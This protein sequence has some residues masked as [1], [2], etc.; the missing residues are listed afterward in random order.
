[1]GEIHKGSLRLERSLDKV[2]HAGIILVRDGIQVVLCLQNTAKTRL[3][4]PQC[5]VSAIFNAVSRYD[6]INSLIWP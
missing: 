3:Q 1:M 5:N 2:F 4:T 6:L